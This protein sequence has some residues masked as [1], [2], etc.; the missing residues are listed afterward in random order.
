MPWGPNRDLCPAKASASMCI[1]SMSMGSCPAVWAVS[2]SNNK[3]F[4]WQKSPISC[5][6]ITVPNTLEA[7]VMIMALVLGRR[8]SGSVE[9]RSVP[10]ESAGIRVKVIS[11][12]LGE[13]F[14]FPIWQRGRITALCSR[15]ETSTWSPG[16]N[17]P[18]IN[19][20]RAAVAPEV[21]TTFLQSSPWKRSH[22]IWRVWYRI[23]SAS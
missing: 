16:F 20:F 4:F 17:N 6:G 22:I 13:V 21:N 1:L 15:E 19:I 9:S 11:S 3:L 10:W 12:G 5:K 7:W 2:T 23:S 14:S 8:S 18:L